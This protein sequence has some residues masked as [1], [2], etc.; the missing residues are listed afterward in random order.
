MRIIPLAKQYGRTSN[1][2]AGRAFLGGQSRF[3]QEG[4]TNA[5]ITR[6][7]EIEICGGGQFTRLRKLKF[8]EAKMNHKKQ[9]NW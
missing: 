1:T 6:S 7:A 4:N 2:T 3:S 9:K 5:C 8:M